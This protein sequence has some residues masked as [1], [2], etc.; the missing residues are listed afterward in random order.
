MA[1]SHDTT[2]GRSP[3]FSPSPNFSY[4]GHH[5]P[6]LVHA[7]TMAERVWGLDAVGAIVH[8][9]RFGEVMLK[10]VAARWAVYDP[11]LTAAQ[12]TRVLSRKGLPAN[13][14]QMFRALR[15]SGNEA[16]HDG[17]GDQHVALQ[18]LKI[19]FQLAVWFQ[20]TF[21]NNRKFDPGPYAPQATEGDT[22]SLR[23]QLEDLTRQA[24]ASRAATE[25]ARAELKAALDAE[26]ARSLGAEHA[27][28][29]AREEAQL[30]EA[31]AA[32]AEAKANNDQTAL[33]LLQTELDAI[34]KQRELE[35]LAVQ[36]EAENAP[37]EQEQTRREQATATAANVELDEAATRV[38]ID[39]QLR[40]AGWEVDSQALR[41]AKGVRP[42]KN[43]FM[44]IA[45]WPTAS[46]PADYVLF[47]GLD[48]VG[49]VEAKKKAKDV[50]SI[51][52]QAKRYSKDITFPE[53]ISACGGPW[54]QYQVPFLF[55]TNGRPYLKQ[56]ETKSGIWHVDVRRPQ[57]L[58]K[59]LTGWHSP[60]GLRQLLKQD[61]DVANDKLRHD[62]IDRLGLRDY[63]ERAIV[64]VETAVTEGAN[65]CLLAMATGTGKTRTA[66][67][68]IYRLLKSGRF[69]RIL[70][71]VD[72][73]AL[74]EQT[75]EALQ[76]TK[77]ENL[78]SFPEIYDVKGLRDITPDTDT[79]LH[80]ATVQGMVRRLLDATDP[81]QVPTVDTYDCIVV[82]ECHRGYGL[83]Q[84]LTEGEF[85]L[86]EYG[87]RTQS[88]YISSYRRVL[89]HF[90]AVKIGLTATPAAHTT[91]I[92]GKPTFQY[93][94][95]EAVIDGHLIDHEPP[96]NLVTKLAEE[97]IHF[98]RGT[99]VRLF[100]P[101][102]SVDS[103]AE[104]EDEVNLEIDS[105]NRRVITE[106]FNR[107]VCTELAKHLDP[108]SDE[109]T[110]IFAATDAHADTVV[111]L[112]KEA[113]QA[114]YG[115]VDDAAV[116]KIT[117][118]ID[119]PLE[120]IRHFKNERY[121]NVAVTVDLLTTGIDVPKIC[122]LVFLRRVRSR[123]LY[124][125]ML[126]RA[127]RLCP[128]INKAA[129]IIYDAV[130]LYEAL[131]PVTNM[132]P[133]VAKPNISFA[134][135][136]RELQ[137]V[138]DEDARQTALEQLIA[139]LQRKKQ[140]MSAEALDRFEAA[141]K[142]GPGE[143]AKL[144][145]QSSPEQA[146]AWFHAHEL[147]LGTLER[148]IEPQALYVSDHHDELLRVERGY[149]NGNKPEDYLDA[150]QRF[151]RDNLNQ[152][153]AL[154][155]VAQR[156]KEL[157]R[158]QLKEVQLLLDA[159]GFTERSLQTAWRQKTNRDIAAT[160]L[161]FIRQAAL[162]DPLVPYEERVE[163]AVHK[164]LASQPWTKPQR[165]WLERIGK[166][167]KKEK[168]VDRPALDEGQFGAKGGFDRLNK[169]FD[170]KL[171]QILQQLSED[172]WSRVG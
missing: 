56:L 91:E 103:L 120:R 143:L 20:R 60:D 155:V 142:M 30:W 80:V 8:L 51:L 82:D 93:G 83:D 47:L 134:E 11:T 116:E 29:K 156:P 118:T 28:T 150:F 164:L 70:F 34:K 33:K 127:T 137:E 117:G 87:I 129:F 15:E 13:I 23:A 86:A 58:A 52:Q 55:A 101:L 2:G 121:P 172:V 61:I 133:V 132:K 53:G 144:L 10:C 160:I 81:C 50:P 35:L 119:K 68:L 145:K 65:T 59:A 6:Q 75:L 66:I 41:Y 37:A 94:Y 77:L 131:E 92:F 48:A 138:E 98:E 122:N 69:R 161:G 149:G 67:G 49:I 162:G 40:E 169:V 79:K 84:E 140:Q 31:Y 114:Q 126:G 147:V 4:L 22:S 88:D 9:R 64:A 159:K 157:T 90:D 148:T 26:Q 141:A 168:V 124:E 107:V 104:L 24:E 16:A 163:K 109:K 153:P 166:Q 110:L 27:A 123:V 171:E 106:N 17:R 89:E 25:A 102:L 97:G 5:E 146:A 42:Q 113:F 21:G 62:P 74:G 38:L 152:L 115:E 39:Q 57:N 96:V 1:N 7:A 136:V 154:I 139:K 112:L 45:E 32:E 128:A 72:R 73:S 108:T 100:D 165:D 76:S 78:Q 151:V 43:K 130:A 170:G 3:A 12:L 167:L 63:Q 125:Q 54:E 111:K 19:A 99:Q 18:H 135:L 36:R 158:A 14:E 95:R 105:F 71:L 46:G 44:A 85:K